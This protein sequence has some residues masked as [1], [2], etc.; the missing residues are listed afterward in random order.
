[1]EQEPL[2]QIFVD[3]RK[4]YDHLNREKCLE[5]MTGYGVGPKLLRL[6]TQFWTQAEM[7]CRAGGSFGKLFAAFR[8]ITQG[9]PL[10]S[11]MFNVCV[12]A[13]IR[14]WLRRMINEDAASRVFSEACREIVAFFVDAGLVRWRDP[15]WLKSAME[16]LVKLFEGIGLRTNH[17]KTKVMMC[18]PGSIQV[19]HT[20]VAYHAQQLGPVNPTAKHHRVECDLCGASLAA[21]SL[22]SHLETQHNTYRLFILNQELTVECEPWVYR[23]NADATGTYFCPVPACV[24]V[25]CSKAVLRSHFLQRHPQDLVCCPMEGSLPL[26]QCDRCRLQIT[27]AAM[28]GRHYE[29]ALCREGIARRVQHAAAKR[30]HLSLNQTFTAYGERL[31]RVEIFKYLG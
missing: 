26:P 16:V 31:E 2:Y 8:G 17:D 5:I 28:N 24:G 27:Y 19:A 23:A 25:A 10:S 1:V 22:R 6:Q 4:A 29:T 21:G 14:E 9:G 30:T 12:D 18:V 15:I 13:V 7:V 3:L 20:E 11:I